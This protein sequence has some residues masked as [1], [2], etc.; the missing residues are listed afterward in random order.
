MDLEATSWVTETS[1]DSAVSLVSEWYLECQAVRQVKALELPPLGQAEVSEA[2]AL[3]KWEHQVC[4][5]AFRADP[6]FSGLSHKPTT[7]YSQVMVLPSILATAMA[8][9]VWVLAAIPLDTEMVTVLE[10]QVSLVLLGL[11]LSNLWR[12]EADP[13]ARLAGPARAEVPPVDPL[14]PLRGLK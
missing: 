12:R 11:V 14:L 7:K 10:A 8:A 2:A 4:L 6:T 5:E 3:L 13:Q 1:E 9:T